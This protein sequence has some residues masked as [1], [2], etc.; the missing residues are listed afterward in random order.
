L[1]AIV[2]ATA[3]VALGFG[4]VLGWFGHR[5]YIISELEAAF[6]DIAEDMDDLDDLDDI[7]DIEVNDVD[8]ATQYI[9]QVRDANGWVLKLPGPHIAVEDL[10][11]L[12]VLRGRDEIVSFFRELFAAVQGESGRGVGDRWRPGGECNA[13][14]ASARVGMGARC[15]DV[16]HPVVPRGATEEAHEDEVRNCMTLRGSV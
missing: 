10:V 3:V 2:A 11:P 13:V 5:A 7:D 4:A 8:Y 15:V 1:I 6:G 12:R 9:P 14:V 16:R